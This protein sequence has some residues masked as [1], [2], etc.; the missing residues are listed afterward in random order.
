[1]GS[2]FL[3][4]V[5][6]LHEDFLFVGL[7]WKARNLILPGLQ[8]LKLW[9]GSVT[10]DFHTPVT[11]GAGVLFVV[12]DLSASDLQTFTVVPSLHQY[13]AS[14]IAMGLLPFMTQLTLNHHASFDATADA[15]DLAESWILPA[16]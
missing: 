9:P 14:I 6:D 10:R 11:D 1:M 16:M 4:V 2:E 13:C 5:D 15:E 8:I 12:L 7:K 3:G